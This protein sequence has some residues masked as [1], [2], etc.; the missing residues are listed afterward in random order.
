MARGVDNLSIASRIK[1]L[2]RGVEH[3]SAHKLTN[4]AVLIAVPVDKNVLAVWFQ[5]RADLRNAATQKYYVG[6]CE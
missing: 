2:S 4:P 1:V 5:K 6:L 3:H